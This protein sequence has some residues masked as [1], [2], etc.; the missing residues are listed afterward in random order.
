MP[1]VHVARGPARTRSQSATYRAASSGQKMRI[2]A[3]SA[4]GAQSSAAAAERARCHRRRKQSEASRKPPAPR[5]RPRARAGSAAK[6]PGARS[7]IAANASESAQPATA[8]P[9]PR[10]G[11]HLSSGMSMLVQKLPGLRAIARQ[12]DGVLV[13]EL[14]SARQLL[15]RIVRRHTIQQCHSSLT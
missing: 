7:Q 4:N 5:D 14:T 2:A 13:C 1:N 8:E 9:T 10:F 15:Q 6:E 12:H 11:K 3:K